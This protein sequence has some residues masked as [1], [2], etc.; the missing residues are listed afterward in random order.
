[1]QYAVAAHVAT[2]ELSLAHALRRASEHVKSPGKVPCDR[3]RH[4]K[5]RRAF[6]KESGCPPQR[7]AAELP[8]VSGTIRAHYLMRKSSFLSLVPFHLLA[9]PH[10]RHSAPGPFDP[11]VLPGLVLWSGFLA[12]TS[13]RIAHP[14]GRRAAAAL[15]SGIYPEARELALEVFPLV[16]DFGSKRMLEDPRCRRA[17]APHPSWQRTCLR[18]TLFF[19]PGGRPRRFF[20]AIESSM[21]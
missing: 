11:R 12:R 18:F 6:S 14:D 13:A 20:R 19:D 15:A 17:I 7:P 9:H 1:M 2:R 5:V 3:V 10:G 8:P 16:L 21:H 4:D